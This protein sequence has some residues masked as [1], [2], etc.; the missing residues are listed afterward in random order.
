MMLEAEV[1]RRDDLYEVQ[2]QGPFPTCLS[3]ATSAVH[4]NH[5]NID[6][7]L[8]AESLHYAASGGSFHT[9]CKMCEVQNALLQT[10]Q[11]KQHHCEPI[12]EQNCDQW[13]PPNNVDYYQSGSRIEDPSPSVVKELIQED[14]LP[15]LGIGITDDFHYPDPPWV[16]SAGSTV[17]YHAVVGVGLGNVEGETVVLIRNSWGNDWAD[18]GHAWLDNSFLEQHLERLLIIDEVRSND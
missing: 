7:P 18:S 6:N 2:D 5:K 8:S 10:G 3:Y 15:V 14:K 9:G 13:S 16:F 12:K 4:K 1:D 11:P 17:G